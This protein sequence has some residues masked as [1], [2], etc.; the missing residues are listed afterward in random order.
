MFPGMKETEDIADDSRIPK[1]KNLTSMQ[2][3]MN[4]WTVESFDESRVPEA[5]K[6]IR[7]NRQKLLRERKIAELTKKFQFGKYGMSRL[8]ENEIFDRVRRYLACFYINE[9]ENVKDRS[10]I[11]EEIWL[12]NEGLPVGEGL[13]ELY[14][15]FCI[16]RGFE[17][18]RIIEDLEKLG[19]RVDRDRHN[20]L[21]VENEWRRKERE[22]WMK[23]K[24]V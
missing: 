22:G 20:E 12:K 18:E 23:Y 1:Q 13:Y 8:T 4:D 7:V 6:A 17:I 16:E 5:I 24:L 15:W 10:K 19:K 2:I 9:F 14:K 3:P 11:S 21:R